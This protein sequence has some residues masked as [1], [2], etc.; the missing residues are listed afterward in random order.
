MY[1]R[2]ISNVRWVTKNIKNR[3]YRYIAQTM[4]NSRTVELLSVQNNLCVSKNMFLFWVVVRS[5]SGVGPDPNHQKLTHFSILAT[6][7]TLDLEGVEFNPGNLVCRCYFLADSDTHIDCGSMDFFSADNPTP[8][9]Y[10]RR[11]RLA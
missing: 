11:P 4:T 5:W 6:S 9:P 7:L 8:E 2:I 1:L 10:Y 3:K